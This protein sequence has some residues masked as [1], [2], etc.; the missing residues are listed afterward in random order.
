QQPG[1]APQARGESPPDSALGHDPDEGDDRLVLSESVESQRIEPP[2]AS[3]TS[4]VTPMLPTRT[5]SRLPVRPPGTITPRTM[6]GITLP[7]SG[8]TVGQTIA[9]EGFLAG[10]LPEQHVFLCVQSQAFGRRI[11]P[12]GKVIPDSTGH[13]T[14]KSIYA[15][16]GYR[17]ATFLVYT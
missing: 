7:H 13:W 15:T 10:L 14:V 12:Q 16:T 1:T 6:T 5:T 9:V 3:P 2:P 4:R 17:Y 8:A 11:Y